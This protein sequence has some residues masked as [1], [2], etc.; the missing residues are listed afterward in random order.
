MTPAP[1]WF[2]CGRGHRLARRFGA[3]LIIVSALSGM[4]PPARLDVA[5]EGLRSQKGL[6]QLCLTRD[7]KH[8]PDC[9]ADPAAHRLTTPVAEAQRIAFNGLPS[10]DYAIALFH[11]ENGN[12]KL[13]TFAGIPR[14]GIGFSRNPRLAFGPPAFDAVRFPL[15]GG[16][17]GQQVKLKYFL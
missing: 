6:V 11:D 7:P 8:F 15:A 16:E 17:T 4:S 9:Q 12:G 10:G 5:V 2:A 1:D 3:A 14:E 13:D